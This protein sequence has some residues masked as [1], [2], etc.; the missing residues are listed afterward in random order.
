MDGGLS[1]ILLRSPL[2]PSHY[3]YYC[4]SSSRL[5]TIDEAIRFSITC[6]VSRGFRGSRL[7]FS[8]FRISCHRLTCLRRAYEGAQ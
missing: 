6:L 8:P 2:P 5:P 1:A 3:Y 7:S 4:E